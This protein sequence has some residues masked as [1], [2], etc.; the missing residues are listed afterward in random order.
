MKTLFNLTLD[1]L[2]LLFEK[3]NK[4]DH[5]YSQ[6][7]LVDLIREFQQYSAFAAPLLPQLVEHGPFHKFYN[8]YG[9]FLLT[10]IQNGKLI[11]DEINKELIVRLITETDLFDSETLQK[12]TEINYRGTFIEE[13]AF[14]NKFPRLE[15]FSLRRDEVRDDIV[16]AVVRHYPELKVFDICTIS[17][18]SSVKVT[19]Y[20]LEM[21]ARLKKLKTVLLHPLHLGRDDTSPSYTGA[22]IAELLKSL[23]ELESF[24]CVG[25]TIEEALQILKRSQT[26]LPTVKLIFLGGDYNLVELL[27]EASEI[28]PSLEEVSV[29]ATY[30]ENS[31]TLEAL[32]AFPNMKRLH[33]TMDGALSNFNGVGQKLSVLELINHALSLQDLIEVGAHCPNVKVLHLKGHMDDSCSS[34]VTCLD[35]SKLSLFPSLET[36]VCDI[37]VFPVISLFMHKDSRLRHFFWHRY[38]HDSIIEELLEKLE[39]GCGLWS[40]LQTFSLMV[41]NCSRCQVA[42]LAEAL[43]S[44][45]HIAMHVRRAND[46]LIY[47]SSHGCHVT[48]YGEATLPPPPPSMV[49]KCGYFIVFKMTLIDY[50]Y[51]FCNIFDPEPVKA[52]R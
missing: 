29:I 45:E 25:R 7:K 52:L 10:F 31:P 20:G 4:R 40:H 32:T 47:V 21:L 9:F 46:E 8:I 26:T 27:E 41:I 11:I 33:L 38:L 1:S 14:L 48:V 35:H 37:N 44:L 50:S 18:F 36:L 49:R 13:E 51:L 16:K 12:V 22:G 2:T 28:F 42:R 17:F 30:E 23:P 15:I 24:F 6:D 3:C 39:S 43:P 19:D 5:E 34:D